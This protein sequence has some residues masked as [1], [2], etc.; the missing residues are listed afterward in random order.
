MSARN[1]LSHSVVEYLRSI[2]RSDRVSATGEIAS[3]TS[4]FHDHAV[5][6][7]GVAMVESTTEGLLAAMQYLRQIQVTRVELEECAL[8]SYLF[9]GFPRMIT[10]LEVLSQIWPDQ[11]RESDGRVDFQQLAPTSGMAERTWQEGI[12]Q[13]N[14]IY[15]KKFDDLAAYMYAVSPTLLAWMIQEGYGKVLSRP[16]LALARRELLNVSMLLLEE[17][18]R[19]LYAHLRGAMNAGVDA[20]RLRN[21]AELHLPFSSTG[22][23]TAIEIIHRLTQK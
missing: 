14:V 7:M 11:K 23:A 1:F 3:D 12:A 9:L 8:Q 21:F 16:G 6:I 10:A 18:E 5:M 17:R 22:A 20:E 4:R 15:G 2:E 13:C 19:Q